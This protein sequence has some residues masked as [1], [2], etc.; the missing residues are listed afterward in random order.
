[1]QGVVLRLGDFFLHP[2]DEFAQ[3]GDGAGDHK[4]VFAVQLL[5][6]DLHSLGIGES[7]AIDD[8]GDHLDFLANG[9]DE[10]KAGVGE[11]DGE[12]DP[13]ETAA[14]AHIENL[15]HG[16]EGHHLGDGQGVE[17]VVLIEVLHILA[18]DDVDLSVPLLIK[19]QQSGKLLALPL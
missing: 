10:G 8:I 11:E 14:G 15:A 4:I 19:R 18:G 2:G 16:G 7:D 5:S 3:R 6:A 17:H 1:M 12:R 13:R 9:V